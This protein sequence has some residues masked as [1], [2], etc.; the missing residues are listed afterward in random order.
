MEFHHRILDNG[1]N[2]VVELNPSVHSIAAG[3]FVRTGA[4]DET[5]DVSGVSHFLEHMAFKGNDRLSADDM[6]RIFDEVGANYNASTGEEVTTYY[7]AVLPEY[8]DRTMGTAVHT[9]A[10]FFEAGGF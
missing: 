2:V 3:F 7:A 9:D 1:L 10:A 5:H 4:R 8:L 6:N